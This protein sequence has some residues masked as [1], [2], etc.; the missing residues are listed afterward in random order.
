MKNSNFVFNKITELFEQ[1][2]VNSKDLAN[3]LTN[4]LSQKETKLYLR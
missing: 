1:G 3:E 4:I 2:L